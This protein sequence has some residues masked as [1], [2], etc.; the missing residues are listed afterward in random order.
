MRS[1]PH[2]VSTTAVTPAAATSAWQIESVCPSSQSL[3]A[4]ALMKL[5]QGL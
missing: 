5:L 2:G 4:I 3:Q 1:V